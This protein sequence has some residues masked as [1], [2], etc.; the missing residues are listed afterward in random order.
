MGLTYWTKFLHPEFE[1][2][3]SEAI[4]REYYEMLGEAYPED[5]IQAYPIAEGI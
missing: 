2:A 3:S 5:L 4:Y 1:L